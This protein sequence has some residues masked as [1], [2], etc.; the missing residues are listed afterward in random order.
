MLAL[1]EY[2]LIKLL[3]KN[4]DGE[5]NKGFEFACEYLMSKNQDNYEQIKDLLY[6][7]Y[8]LSGEKNKTK[9][10]WNVSTNGTSANISYYD[11]WE[12]ICECEHKSDLSIK[13]EQFIKA[14]DE[15]SEAITKY[16]DIQSPTDDDFNDLI[17]VITGN[18][19][20]VLKYCETAIDDIKRH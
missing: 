6:I 5:T 20:S 8:I 2:F 7:Q 16:K 19:A 3:D 10:G 14:I 11:A 18:T 4:I 9:N 15:V 13:Y 1:K 12:Y 17:K